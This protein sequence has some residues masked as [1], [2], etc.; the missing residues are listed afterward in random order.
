MKLWQLTSLGL[1]LPLLGIGGTQGALTKAQ[2]DALL[3]RKKWYVT[4]DF[5]RTGSGEGWKVNEH[6]AGMIELNAAVP[7]LF[8][9]SSVPKD[10]VGPGGI[11]TFNPLGEP[12]RFIGW[13]AVPD[14]K[15]QAQAGQGQVDPAKMLGIFF[16]YTRDTNDTYGDSS[17]TDT[18]R[19]AGTGY[20]AGA[21]QLLFDLKQETFDL[22]FQVEPSDFGSKV[23]HEWHH[24]DDNG[25]EDWASPGSLSG[26]FPK[27]WEPRLAKR[28]F[29][30]DMRNLRSPSL[31]T[32]CNLQDVPAEVYVLRQV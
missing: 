5:S 20:V 30:Q 23:I 28:K 17:N 32:V 14:E 16:P 18:F 2:K 3:S 21:C 13:W 22:I 27:E 8:P 11:P 9:P 19:G 26:W 15:T 25:T 6:A 31:A 12:G 7:G 24:K 1:L 4:Y 10:P 29:S